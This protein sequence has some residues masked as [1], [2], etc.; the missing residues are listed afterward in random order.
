MNFKEIR[1]YNE[2]LMISSKKYIDQ[3]FSIIPMKY[4]DKKPLIK[5]KEQ[6]DKKLSFEEFRKIAPKHMHL[7]VWIV[8]W[9]ISWIVVVDIDKWA[10][11]EW[12]DL[13][14][15]VT[16][17]SG[18]GWIHMYYKYPKWLQKIDSNASVIRKHI[19]IRWDGGCIIAPPSI[20][21]SWNFY[22]WKEGQWIDDIEMADFPLEI[23][24]KKGNTEKKK[25]TIEELEGMKNF[26]WERNSRT[27]SYAWKI[28]KKNG[29]TDWIEKEIE[30]YN[31]NNNVPSLDKKEIQ[32]IVLYVSK[33]FTPGKHKSWKDKKKMQEIIIISQESDNEV[34][35]TIIDQW[36]PKMWT[37]DKSNKDI[38]L[39]TEFFSGKYKYISLP[40]ENSLLKSKTILFPNHYEEESIEK[41][42]LLEKI[43]EFIYK[44]VDCSGE[45]LIICTY[46]VLFSYF[47]KNYEVVPYLRVIWDYGSWKSQL[48]KT[49]WC[50]CYNPILMNGSASIATV[51][52]VISM[53]KWTLIYDEADIID[54]DTTNEFIKILNNGYQKGM[55]VLRCNAD[56]FS[57]ASFEVFGPKIIWW[58][59]EFKDKATESRCLTEIMKQTKR[60]DIKEIDKNFHQEAENIRN[61]CFIYWKENI[62]IVFKNQYDLEW[63]EPRQKQILKPLLSIVDNEKDAG[64]IIWRVKKTQES[65]IEDRKFSLE[66]AIFWEISHMLS[67]ESGKIYFKEILFRINQ[68][69]DYDFRFLKGRTIWTIVRQYGL[70]SDRDNVGTFISI[71]INRNIIKEVLSRFHI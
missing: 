62:G 29:T 71:D 69:E 27:L 59:M 56:D 37:Y 22:K 28:A 1:K 41:N 35:E 14:N 23:L 4:Q 50:L 9:R 31:L 70:S 11:L 5:W 46:Y 18:G 42:K 34:I 3:W 64:A 51:F 15:T 40:I 39:Q 38:Y 13:P 54:S 57:P 21:S 6:Q 67:T 16:V 33:K 17:E 52:R 30:K 55:S 43:K 53:V 12:L 45:F 26:E 20:H 10:D 19:D 36:I 2:D 66:W 24:V 63:I 47:Y 58:R 49:V 44:Y 8:T 7:N 32:E 61:L 65:L 48:L 60:D 25:F 68:N